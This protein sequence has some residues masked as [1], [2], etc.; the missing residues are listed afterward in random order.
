MDKKLDRYW[1]LPLRILLGI[2]FLYHGLPKFVGG[3]AGFVGMLQKMG[4]PAPEFWAWLVALVEVVGG[5]ALIVG[6]FVSI[7]AILLIIEMLVAM[8]MVHL[9]HGFGFLNITGMTPQGPQFGMPGVEV[10]LLYIA[11]LLSLLLGGPGPLSVDER[12]LKPES[13][14]R[15]PWRHEPPARP[16]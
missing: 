4:L 13:P 16:A 11:G 1:P 3:H 6:A 12:V 10:N 5:I 14:L 2:A 7:F 9:P 8:F 15:L